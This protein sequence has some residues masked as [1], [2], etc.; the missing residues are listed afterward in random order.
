[1]LDLANN[2]LD[3]LFAMLL[4]IFDFLSCHLL[5]LLSDFLNE[6]LSDLNLKIGQ[7]GLLHLLAKQVLNEWVD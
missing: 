3:L 6:L 4:H 7:D 5:V 1:M 2:I